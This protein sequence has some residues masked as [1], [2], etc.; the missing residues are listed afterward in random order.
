MLGAAQSI[1]LLEYSSNLAFTSMLELY[2]VHCTF[3][4]RLEK[5]GR[6]VISVGFNLQH[7]HQ[8]P[9][10]PTHF[11]F[12]FSAC[13]SQTTRVMASAC[14]VHNLSY[15]VIDRSCFVGQIY[16]FVTFRTRCWYQLHTMCYIPIILYQR[17]TIVMLITISCNQQAQLAIDIGQP[18]LQ[19][20]DILGL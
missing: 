9:L 3:S 8:M 17:R 6:G 2:I 7:H 11:T 4:Y 16:N 19:K 14:L 1:E 13:A 5:R 10:N 20:C 15:K 12:N 18:L